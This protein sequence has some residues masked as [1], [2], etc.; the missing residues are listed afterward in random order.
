MGKP[1][2][3]AELKEK[4]INFKKID[5]VR[6]HIEILRQHFDEK[7]LQLYIRKHLLWCAKEL[8]LATNLKLTLATCDDVD[9]CLDI[10]ETAF[11][12]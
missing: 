1:W 10:L 3:F 9:K 11:E 2:L 5:V 12:N 7:W 4:K 8:P 6:K